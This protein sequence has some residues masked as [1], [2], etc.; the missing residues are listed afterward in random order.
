MGATP[1]NHLAASLVDFDE[2]TGT[3]IR[4]FTLLPCLWWL[5]PQTPSLLL[6]PPL[7]PE[8]PLFFQART[9]S[10]CRRRNLLSLGRPHWRQWPL[11]LSCSSSRPR[12]ASPRHPFPPVCV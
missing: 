2:S 6:P 11:H 3:R 7:V 8:A 5:L 1:E 4:R 9:V 10:L 12:R